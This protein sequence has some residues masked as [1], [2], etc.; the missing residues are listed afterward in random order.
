MSTFTDP[1]RLLPQDYTRV[2]NPVRDY[3]EQA[4]TYLQIETGQSQEQ[5]RDFIVQSLKNK[6]FP[7][8]RNPNV[9]FLHRNEFGD[10]QLE[11]ISLTGYIE[12]T[13]KNKELLAPTMTTYLSPADIESLLV[14]YTD[15]NVKIRSTAKKAMFAAK[16]A[17]DK[18]QEF[19]ED[20]TQRNTK[21]SN[22]AISGAH[23]SNSNILYNQ[24]AH[25]TLTSNCRLTSGY[26][27][28]NNEK[29]LSGNR[30]YWS[31]YIVL[32]NIISI[33]T[34]TDYPLLQTV[35]EKYNLIYPTVDQALEC[36]KYSTSAYWHSPAGMQWIEKLLFKLT[37]IQRAAFV[38]T[39]DLYHVMKF[40]DAIVRQFIGK[41]SMKITGSVDNPLDKIHSFHEDH[42]NLAHQ[43]CSV[44]MKDKGK[45]YNAI[46]DSQ[47]LQT[48]YLTTENIRNTITEYSDFIKAIMVTDNVPASIGHFPNSLRRAA[49]TS[50]TDS[51]IFT[52]QD[53]VKWYFGSISFNTE[54]CAI[55]ATMIF[56]ASQ[57]IVHILARM[58]KNFGI[59]DKRLNQIAMKNEF[60]FPVFIPTNVT[61]HYFALISVQEGNVFGK[62]KKEIK[63][64][65][66]K[67]SNAPKH[68]TKLATDFMVD[69]MT[70]V[71][72]NEKLSLAAMLKYVADIERD[73]YKGIHNA[74]LTYF[75]LGEI[76]DPK[77]YVKEKE[78]S[79]YMYHMFWN[80]TF[81]VKYSAVAEPPYKALRV[82]TKLINHTETQKWLT[83]MEDQVLATRLKE[84]LAKMKKTE[85]PSLLIPL[86][87]VEAY[88]FP[89]EIIDIIDSRNIVADLSKIFYLILETTG[90]YAMNPHRTTL[91][92]DYY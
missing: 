7:N 57:A 84:W 54:A 29:L 17:G 67:S 62:L 1:F 53:W 73:I 38:Y 89:K 76:K 10:R 36:V 87:I 30:H 88:G 40:N 86:S 14:R 16:A 34:H 48:L 21:L 47:E 6:T 18:V 58:S 28:A 20:V 66:L 22:T 15:T 80:E 12:D 78:R 43:I 35:M 59:E 82:S 72:S 81:G 90:F 39:G 77:S 56:I 24:T 23:A 37:P 71:Y 9:K 31:A 52:V 45:D 50:D 79:P 42:L 91:I 46:K 26:G 11:E 3:I 83:E 61:K 25:S 27:N 2:I 64:V 75:R 4:C 63:G 13:L 74:D 41:L 44:E 19:F 68:I 65:H 49:I 33:I 32:N 55:G 51:T 85:L 8:V 5:C 69:I 70:K 60:Y 92:S